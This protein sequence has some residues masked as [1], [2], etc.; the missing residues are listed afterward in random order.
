VG[1]LVV[2]TDSTYS[3]PVCASANI[4]VAQPTAG[5]YIALAGSCTHACCTGNNLSFGTGNTTIQCGCHG[6]IFNLDGSVAH[7]PATQ[8]LQQL[9]V[10][11][12]DSSGVQISVP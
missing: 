3:D 6:S 5:N 8:P 11:S 1:G 7:G 2:V 4:L 12:S 10:C 9:T